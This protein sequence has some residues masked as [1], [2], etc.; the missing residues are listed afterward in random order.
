M[1]FFLRICVFKT[2]RKIR[3]WRK[4]KWKRRSYSPDNKVDISINNWC[5][6]LLVASLF[7]IMNTKWNAE[8]I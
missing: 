4:R 8:V 7:L 1:K 5:Y 3:E 6:L 2:K